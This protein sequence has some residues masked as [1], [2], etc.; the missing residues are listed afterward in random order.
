MKAWI[1]C[2]LISKFALFQNKN[3]CATIS[4]KCEW[5]SMFPHIIFDIFSRKKNWKRNR[6]ASVADSRNEILFLNVEH[7]PPSLLNLCSDI[8]PNTNQQQK[9]VSSLNWIELLIYIYFFFHLIGCTREMQ[10]NIEFCAMPKTIANEQYLLLVM[11]SDSECD[12]WRNN[13]L[14]TEID[15][16]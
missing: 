13:F 4:H 12:E 5:A 7:S 15:T 16:D 8:R 11:T 3:I 9:S 6:W 1:L 2:K 14:C 10:S